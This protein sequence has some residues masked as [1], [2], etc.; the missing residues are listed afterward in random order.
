MNILVP[1]QFAKYQFIT[2]T[3][4]LLNWWI[5]LWAWT[6][7]HTDEQNLQG[8]FLK[9]QINDLFLVTAPMAIICTSIDGNILTVNPA[10][11][12]I[13]GF[14]EGELEGKNF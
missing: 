1:L 9:Q 12:E 7:E 13:F 6:M 4:T 14:L 8:K 10:V 2:Y 3:F 5:N 11:R